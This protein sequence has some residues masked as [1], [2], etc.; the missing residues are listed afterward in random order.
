MNF[1]F[2]FFIAG[3]LMFLATSTSRA[4]DPATVTQ[5]RKFTSQDGDVS[6]LPGAWVS[7]WNNKDYKYY[8]YD[9]SKFVEMTALPALLQGWEVYS[10]D[11]D[12]FD[13]LAKRDFDPAISHALPS[14]GK[15]KKVIEISKRGYNLTLVCYTL[16]ATDPDASPNVTDIYLAI[17]VNGDS[18]SGPTYK[19]LKTEKLESDAFY[20]QMSSQKINSFG[21]F[22]I[23]YWGQPT[24]DSSLDG[25][26][27]YKIE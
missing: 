2:W 4:S 3:A 5:I 14:L 10:G 15:V 20:G 22:L 12:Y 24:A 7:V 17:F 1:R 27:I 9:G 6:F 16:K 19:L 11:A 8:R 23:L 21:N 13:Q 25:L 18:A 26:D